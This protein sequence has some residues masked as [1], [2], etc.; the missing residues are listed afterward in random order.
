MDNW[1]TFSVDILQQLIGD[2]K[3]KKLREVFEEMNIVD[4]AEMV[5]TLTLPEVLFIFKTIKNDITAEL[6]SYL[7]LDKQEELTQAFTGPEIKS[8]LDNLYLDDIVDFLEEMP[9]SIV[10]KVLQNATLE[11]RSEINMLLSFKENSAGSI[12][13]TDYVE[14]FEHDTVVDAMERIRKQGQTA[15]TINTC[16]VIN[17]SNLLLGSVSLK[18][19]LFASEESLIQDIMETD[20]ATVQTTDDQE[21]IVRVFQK[22][23][24]SVVPVVNNQ[25]RMVGII[26]VDDVIDVLE[27]EATEDIHL[28]AAIRPLDGSYLE[29]DTLSMFKSRIPWLL[30]LM[31]SATVTDHIITANSRLYI[32]LPS[33]AFF[34]PMLMDTAGNAGSQAS[35]MVIRGIVV[36]SLTYKDFFKILFKELRVALVTGFILFVV[37]T[38]R[39]GIFMP[40]VGWTVA[41]MVSIAIFATILMSK[42]IGGCLPLLAL[43]L[44]IDPAVMSGPVITTTVDAL[45]LMVYFAIAIMYLGV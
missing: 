30:V 42:L 8:I 23:D 43:V 13:T 41:I 2:K 31:I 45:S 7:S 35:A 1:E 14:L 9:E 10:K 6:F 18:E 32:I 21:V 37:N 15:E 20:I 4:L 17:Q 38:L 40:S 19:I 11:Q 27:E 34:I 36:D 24:I 33:L 5:E 3:V 22:Y 39:I 12:M 16:F 44:K 29:A 28:M 26:T 25:Y